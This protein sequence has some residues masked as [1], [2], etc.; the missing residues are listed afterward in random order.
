[1]EGDAQIINKTPY[2]KIF[3]PKDYLNFLGQ[4]I[5]KYNKSVNRLILVLGLL[6]KNEILYEL[7]RKEVKE[8]VKSSNERALKI[9]I[10][11][12][13]ILQFYSDL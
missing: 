10:I 5:K 1:M 3:S 6:E 12:D 9:K 8:Q 2:K 7:D 11:T 4:E 13:K